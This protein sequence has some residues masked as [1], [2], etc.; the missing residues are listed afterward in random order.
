MRII[1]LTCIVAL[2]S[3]NNKTTTN[4]HILIV[5]PYGDIEVELYPKQ[6]PIT[7][8]AFLS[9]IKLGIYKNTSFYR[10]LKNED[11]TPET[12][13]GVIQGGLWPELS[14]ANEIDH[15]STQK[16]GLSH[17]SGTISLARLSSGKA[18]T[19]FFICIGEQKIFDAGQAMPNDKQGFAAFGRVVDGMDV[20]R[21]IQNQPSTGDK[22]LKKIDITNIE[23]L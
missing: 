23:I 9:N 2:L 3:C 21:K 5:S 8:A 19:E 7:V 17:E 18:S 12:N 4:P 11:L 10:V 1:L 22:F 16:T 15:E 13:Y 6:A 14:K 20:V